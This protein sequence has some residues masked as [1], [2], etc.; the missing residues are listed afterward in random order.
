MDVPT[1][2]RSSRQP[3]VTSRF[4]LLSL[5]TSSSVVD[6]GKH[7]RF[8]RLPLSGL[9][10][11][12][13]VDHVGILAILSPGPMLDNLIGSRKLQYQFLFVANRWIGKVGSTLEREDQFFS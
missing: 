5:L 11:R 7:S 8:A 9:T 4:Q 10:T 12:K 13:A 1:G 6:R 3:S 2:K